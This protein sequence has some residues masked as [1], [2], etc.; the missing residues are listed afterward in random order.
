M[1]RAQEVGVAPAANTGIRITR[2]IRRID[3]PERRADRQ[4]AGERTAFI[5]GVARYAVARARKVFAALDQI[6]AGQ[7]VALHDHRLSRG[8]LRVRRLNQRVKTHAR[9]GERKNGKRAAQALVK[10]AEAVRVA[11]FGVLHRGSPS[12]RN[13]SSFFSLSASRSDNADNVSVQFTDAAV[14]ITALPAMKRFGWSCVRH[15]ESTTESLGSV[16]MMVVPMMWLFGANL[17]SK[18][19]SVPPNN[20]AIRAYCACVSAALFFT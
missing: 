20:S 1:H 10:F 4:A 9:D 2:D 8:G 6:L 18:L 5:G 12:A 3:G 14:G 7:R 11:R 13:Q 15:S 19:I 17:S 16:P